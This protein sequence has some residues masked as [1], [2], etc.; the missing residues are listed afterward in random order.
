MRRR[1]TPER[2]AELRQWTPERAARVGYLTGI[3]CSAEAVTA[4]PDVGARSEQSVRHVATRWRLPL[5]NGGL[6]IGI[7]ISPAD[8][9]LLEHAAS[10]RGLSVASLIANLVNV[11]SRE[12][13]VDAVLD[14][15]R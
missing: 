14:D 4:D 11:V 15:D 3:G 9:E 1:L 8:Q 13:L 7:P 6:R 5:G 10:A 12:R 2:A